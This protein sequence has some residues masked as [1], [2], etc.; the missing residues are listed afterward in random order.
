MKKFNR[1]IR[2]TFTVK[3]SKGVDATFEDIKEAEAFYVKERQI[4]VV[5]LELDQYFKLT[6]LH[7]R[8]LTFWSAD[9]LARWLQKNADHISGLC[10]IWVS[11][12]HKARLKEVFA[13]EEEELE[14]LELEE[15]E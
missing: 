5:G 7:E 13:Q 15:E 11:E 2:P 10:E 9:D 3:D 1:N 6:N 4:E 12:E 14:E 8:G